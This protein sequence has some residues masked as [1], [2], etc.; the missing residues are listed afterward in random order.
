MFSQ[1]NLC[2]NKYNI[3]SWTYILRTVF[4]IWKCLTIGYPEGG[5]RISLRNL[6]N[7]HTT[8]KSTVL[9]LPFATQ[10]LFIYLNVTVRESDVQWWHLCVGCTI[11]AT[12]VP[13]SQFVF[14][15]QIDGLFWARDWYADCSSFVSLLYKQEP[16]LILKF[17]GVSRRQHASTLQVM[18][19]FSRQ[20]LDGARIVNMPSFN[21]KK[22]QICAVIS[23]FYTVHL[24]HSGKHRYHML[25]HLKIPLYRVVYLRMCPVWFS[26]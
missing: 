3:Y 11:T 26:E 18:S 4:N 12:C 7:Y 24:K 8:Q 15:S 20:Q 2:L 6:G 22:G 17:K 5:S 19:L 13:K 23:C 21:I 10:R 14:Q 25:Q 1:F 16:Q 9:Y